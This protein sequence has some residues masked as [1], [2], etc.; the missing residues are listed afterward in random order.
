MSIDNESQ[1]LEK[2]VDD[3]AKKQERKPSRPKSK[4]NSILINILRA[5][6]TFGLLFLLMRMIK[7][8]ALLE[9][10][11]QA[12]FI[13]MFGALILVPVNLLLQGKRWH[14]LVKTEVPEM[15]YTKCLTSFLG[16]LSMGLITPGR[17]GEIGRV[18]LLNVPSR[19]RLAGLHV[20]DKLYF[21][22]AV[23]FFGP[24]LLY[25]MPGFKDALPE[26]LQ[27]GA[28]IVVLTFPLIYIA[29]VVKPDIIKSLLV[30]VQLVIGAKGKV[31]ELLRAYENVKTSH[32]LKAASIT[33]IQFAVILTQ[34]YFLSYAFEP[35]NWLVAAHTY[36]SA[37]FVKV[38]LPISLGSLG[39]GEW[40]T[41]SF[42]TRYGIAETTGFSASLLLF[43]M[44]VL[45][46]GLGG[47]FV[48]QKLQPSL[49]MNK[50]KNVWRKA[51]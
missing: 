14:I 31:L 36:A 11:K 41:V 37:L 30:A 35:V 49:I 42:Y 27:L 46:P 15:K 8:D 1:L 13:W 7:R 22:G 19:T 39:V 12:K 5:A 32:C 26:G 47:L 9:A 43:G 25:F 51:A 45:L 44:N 38:A 4:I 16:G 17:V 40:A 48:L 20:L 2:P 24:A 33:M 50:I 23:G 28:M 18:F 6:I 3:L 29:I 21:V 34:F 10:I